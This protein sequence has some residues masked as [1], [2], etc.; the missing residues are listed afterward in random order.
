V[1]TATP[2]ATP[3]PKTFW[4]EYG[5]NVITGLL[6]LIIGGVLVWLL[7]PV[8]E[9]L[10]NALADWLSRL[11]AGRSFRRWY[12]DYLVDEYRCLN[13]RGLRTRA[14]VAV[15]L[16]QVY[17][18]LRAEVP[19]AEL[20][21]AAA[22]RSFTIGQVMDRDERLAIV[23]GPGCGKTTLLA[24]LTLTYARDQA[25]EQLGL[26]EKKEKRL[27]I[28]V[29]LRLLKTVLAPTGDK[30]PTTLPQYLDA[31][32]E[33][34][35]HKPPPGFFDGRLQAG[36]CLVLLDGLD[37]VADERER[38]QM[39]EWVDR[40]VATYPVVYVS[41][42]DARAYAEWAG[43]QL[44]SEAQ[45]EKA[46][47][48]GLQ[49]PNP[50]SQIP[51][52]MVDNPNPRRRYPWGDEFDK[53]RCNTDESGIGGTTPVGKYSP[54]GDSPYGVADVAGNVWEWTSSLYKRYPYQ[55]DDG[56]EDEE[57]GG[58]RVLRGGSW[59]LTLGYARCVYRYWFYPDYSHNYV[60]FRLV[61][62]V[63]SL[64]SEF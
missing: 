61:S 17:V 60:G 59:N 47:R 7:K 31:R 15:E 33:E 46:A 37:E 3:G 29:P 44:L 28:L 43:L 36:E 8:F 52:E 10:G 50:K 12:L 26:K 2:S 25:E 11:G 58:D 64:D 40:L 4:G 14:P 63:L 18:S 42:Y 20:E 38:R 49:I 34:L 5:D 48:G 6:G 41:W 45:W 55:A 13:I 53:S 51:S 1:V 39:A 32:Y 19:G 57:P 21:S 23:G 62:P 24:Y 35:D 22:R 30:G 54:H 56:R 9:R 16:E 27:P